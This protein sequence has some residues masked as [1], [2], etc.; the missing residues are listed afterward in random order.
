MQLQNPSSPA[1]L[2]PEANANQ[3][4][5]SG[6]AKAGSSNVVLEVLM[7]IR[8]QA[9]STDLKNVNERITAATKG[10]G[11]ITHV[12]GT[13]QN[14]A[15]TSNNLQSISDTIDTF[16]AVLGPIKVFNSIANQI[17]EVQSFISTL[18]MTANVQG[19]SI[20]MQR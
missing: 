13:V 11:G 9:E 4:T 12:P 17:A 1:P 18:F 3:D 20:R 8:H 10:V 19:R 6:I 7:I 5:N 15:S 2:T 16:S 14:I